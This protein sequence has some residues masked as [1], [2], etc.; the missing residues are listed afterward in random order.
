MALVIILFIIEFLLLM[1]V[2]IS[3]S[4]DYTCP[5][6]LTLIMFSLSTLSLVYNHANWDVRFHFTTFAIIVCGLLTLVLVDLSVS[7]RYQKLRELRKDSGFEK[8]ESERP[9]VND[10]AMKTIIL[11][12]SVLMMLLYLRDVRSIGRLLSSTSLLSSIG[13]VQ[14]SEF[15]TGAIATI[16]LRIGYALSNLYAFI[17]CHNVILSRQKIRKNLYLLVA[18]LTG[19]VSTFFSGSRSLLLGTVFAFIFFLITFSR[20]R[21]G[22]KEIKINRYLKYIIPAGIIFILV[23]YGFRNVIKNRQYSVGLLDYI[24]YYIGNSQQLLNVA[25]QDLSA[26]WPISGSYPGLYTFQFL[27]NELAGYR[28]LSVPTHISSNFMRMGGSGVLTRG[29]VYT[30]FGEPYHD[31]GFIGML[32]FV[33]LFYYIFCHFY[34]KYIRNWHNREKNKRVLLVFGS[35]YYYIVLTFYTTP[36]VWF[37]IQTIISLIIVVIA[38]RFFTKCR[39]S[40]RTRL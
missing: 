11:V 1:F 2:V 5:S 22:W 27:Y 24:T 4:F 37:K 10:G 32:V 30:L 9:W 16:C 26:A 7:S 34:Y 14:Q 13:A 8:V 36:T 6:F 19:V 35:M 25:T 33:A 40:R 28:I 31:F 20:I 17:F 23:F 15:H 3:T 18:M 38:Y 12:S 21:G 29:N 39:F